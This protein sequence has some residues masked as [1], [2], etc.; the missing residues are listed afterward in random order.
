MNIDNIKSVLSFVAVGRLN[1]VIAKYGDGKLCAT[2]KDAVQKVAELVVANKV[3]MTEVKT[4]APIDDVPSAPVASGSLALNHLKQDIET[5][6][7][8]LLS[9]ANT[10]KSAITEARDRKS[11]R[12]NSS[13]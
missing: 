13:H 10:A 2:K 8:D 4:I 6:N 3:A 9:V 11:T 7:A 1:A 5:L 12:L